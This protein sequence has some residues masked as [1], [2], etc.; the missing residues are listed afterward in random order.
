MPK[1]PIFL[2]LIFISFS[3]KAQT[4]GGYP[5]T[6]KWNNI[7]IPSARIIFPKGWDSTAIRVASLIES[8]KNLKD[9]SIGTKQLP[10]NIVLQHGT[11]QSNGYV[12]LAPFR[13]EFMIAPPA[14]PFELGSLT[15]TDQLALHEFR[16]VQQCRNLKRGLAKVFRIALGQQGQAFA[17]ALTI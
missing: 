11:T 12:A 1:R 8:I 2:L 10:I 3:V 4:F 9:S 6:Q 16:H 5:P 17:N 13:S 15:W 14:N 7:R